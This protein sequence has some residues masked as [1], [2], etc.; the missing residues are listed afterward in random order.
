MYKQFWKIYIKK[1]FATIW[2]CR[3]LELEES[4]VFLFIFRKCKWQQ[5]LFNCPWKKIR[6]SFNKSSTL[7]NENTSTL[8]SRPNFKTPFEENLNKEMPLCSHHKTSKLYWCGQ[9]IEFFLSHDAIINMADLRLKK[10]NSI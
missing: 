2:Y 8:I 1:V 9:G 3:Y 7:S 6:S 4:F 10:I 5:I